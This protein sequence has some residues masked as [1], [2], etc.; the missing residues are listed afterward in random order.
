MVMILEKKKEF[1][2]GPLSACMVEANIGVDHLMYSA[3]S[4][5]SMEI[6]TICLNYAFFLCKG[7]DRTK[8]KIPK[9][10]ECCARGFGKRGSEAFESLI[11]TI[12][13]LDFHTDNLVFFG[14]HT[15]TFLKW[16]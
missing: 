9:V 6:V 15:I 2:E 8:S 16:S 4:E 13:N 5:G 7:T 3:E 10:G 1:V 12:R 11:N 14:I